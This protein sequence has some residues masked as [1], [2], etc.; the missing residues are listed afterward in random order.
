MHIQQM[1]NVQN[2]GTK[3]T[4]YN[5]RNRKFARHMIRVHSKT[6]TAKVD[7]GKNNVIIIIDSEKTGIK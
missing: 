5:T 1:F 3:N 4:M 7:K 6:K 2:L